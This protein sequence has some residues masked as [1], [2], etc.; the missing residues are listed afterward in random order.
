MTNCK[1]C[2]LEIKPNWAYCPYCGKFNQTGGITEIVTT[3]NYKPIIPPIFKRPERIQYRRTKKDYYETMEQIKK[4]SP[5][6]YNK[7][8]KQE[9]EQLT[10]LYSEGKKIQ[11]IAIQLQRQQGGIRAR[12]Q[13]TGLIQ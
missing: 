10:K 3:T 12:L 8:T 13:K 9:E 11:E 1:N 7:W 2:K 5:N 4:E 6:A